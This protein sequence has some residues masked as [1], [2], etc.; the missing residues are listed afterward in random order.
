MRLPILLLTVFASAL[1]AV[2][3]GRCLP[4]KSGVAKTVWVQ[5]NPWFPV[6]MAPVYDLGGPNVPYEHFRGTN[7][8][9]RALET[10]GRYGID[11]V[12]LELNFPSGSYSSVYRELLDAAARVSP[13]MRIGLF[14]GFRGK[15]VE[16][17]IQ[18][19]KAVLGKFRE[20]LRS[21]PYVSRY[22]GC[23]V[24]LV[25]NSVRYKPAEWR[26]IFEALDAEFGKMCFLMCYSTM[27][28]YHPDKADFEKTIREYL[29]EFDGVS[30]YCY[31]R[32]SVTVQR[33]EAE[34]LGRIMA[35]NPEK[36]F[37]GGMFFTYTQHFNMVGMD[38]HLSKDW[39]ASVRLWLS[40]NTDAI[41]I[42]NLF[43]HYE[44]S[45]V[46][47]CFER[48][49]LLLRY[50]QY[51]LSEWRGSPFPRERRPE[52]V[53]CNYTTALIGWMALDFEV[54]GF[55]IDAD[56]REVLV[57][58]ELCDTAGKVLR[59]LGPR[60]MVLDGF[61]DCTFS[62]KSTDF[63]DERGI[64]P[65]LVYQWGEET[66]RMNHNPMTLL[67]PSIRSHRMFWARST[68]NELKPAGAGNWTMDGV[69]AGGLHLPRRGGNSVFAADFKTEGSYQRH[70]VRRDGTELFFTNDPRF[71]W[72][73]Q[74]ALPIP[75]PGGALHWYQLEVQ[76][77]DGRKFQTLP[78]WETDGTRAGKVN[79]PIR[80]ED[81]TVLE[82]MIE[83][84]RVPFFH[85]PC[86]HDDGKLLVDVSG[87]MHNAQVD[88][89]GYGGGHLGYTG[90]NLCHNGP[91]NPDKGWV[92]P[93]C[94]DADG[95]G[96]LRL[97]GKNHVMAMG[98]TVMPAASTYEICVRPREFGKR[99]GL[100]G[101]SRA[102]AAVSILPDGRVWAG[103]RTGLQNCDADVTVISRNPIAT[104]RWTRIAIVY[105]M[106]KLALYVN[107]SLQG[108]VA[109]R[110]NYHDMSAVGNFEDLPSHEYENELIIGA[111]DERMYTPVNNFIGDI[112]DIRVYGRNLKPE[113]LL[114]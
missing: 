91:V 47:P 21:N 63:A 114:Q 42:T 49:D 23:P 84:A 46:Y 4:D 72:Q 81:G 59:T 106:R 82:R 32:E 22:G 79:V 73:G 25:Y 33:D 96:Y 6:D 12:R 90:Y 54:L 71:Q 34:I 18:G 17:S 98:C 51:E 60:K 9:Q 11:G 31:N 7:S 65:R 105:D 80:N 88:G 94:R 35:E 16:D 97:S 29:P 99:M 101:S 38:P 108:A 39:R 8:W 5:A 43:D 61:R 55:P 83:A 10:V 14:C 109:A 15:T 64:V 44:N 30:S 110:P 92:S 104:N 3:G 102:A 41:E 52:L 76:E 78:I 112:R 68:R 86:D 93:F 2:A 1:A 74:F 107:G 85:W 77:V 89:R 111:E 36:V 50:L 37:E 100:L 13:D 62:V 45:L 113:E 28:G 19:A 53:L 56:D 57:S 70:G 26:R 103:R 24:V 87:Y 75:D 27:K 67:S 58:V 95:I 20:D 48:E 66:F 69:P 40:A